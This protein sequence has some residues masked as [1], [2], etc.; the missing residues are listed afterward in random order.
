VAEEGVDAALVA[1]A[2]VGHSPAHV[3]QH[4]AVLA[5]H[6]ARHGGQRRRDEIEVGGGLAAAEVGECP[7]C[8]AEQG[9]LVQAG[10]L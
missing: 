6:Q 2:E 5:Q 10:G 1:V 8:V 4:F 9:L 7:S 3:R